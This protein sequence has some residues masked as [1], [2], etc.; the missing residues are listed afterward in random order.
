MRFNTLFG[1]GMVLQRG[2]PIPICGVATAGESIRV[3]LGS[4][5]LQA[6]ANEA[7]DWKVIFPAR[8]SGASLKLSATGS[9]GQFQQF[10]DIVMGD[11]WLASGQSNMGWTIEDGVYE[12]QE[13]IAAANY[14]EIRFFNVPTQVASFPKNELETPGKWRVCSPKSVNQMSA[15]AYFFARKIN[16]E[17]GV[18]IGI[19]LS[20]WGGSSIEAWMP[21]DLVKELPHASG[22]E[23]DFDR[24]GVENYEALFEI[25]ERRIETIQSLIESPA[26]DFLSELASPDIDD[27]DW[28]IRSIPDWDEL[29]AEIH[30]FRKSFDWSGS[31]NEPV[32]ASLGF[33][34]SDIRVFLNGKE[35]FCGYVKKAAFE[36]PRRLLREGRNVMVMRLANPWFA[37][38][39]TGEEAD[40][41]LYGWETETRVPLYEEWRVNGC[42]EPSLPRFYAMQTIPSLLYNG[43][44]EPLAQLRYCGVLWYQGENNGE[45]GYE[46]RALFSA[47]IKCWRTL[48]GQDELPFLFVQLA[49]HGSPNDLPE[50]EGWPCLR[51][52]QSIALDLPMT[53][54][55][56][57]IDVGDEHDIHPQNKKPVGERL[58]LLA[59]QIVYG[60][61]V[62]ANGPVFRSANF[63][64]G[65][66]CIRFTNSNGMQGRGGD[67]ILGFSI[68]GS[69][70]VFHRAEVVVDGGQLW[71][72][73][74]K[75]LEPCSVRYAWAKNPIANLVNEF[76]LPASPFRTDRW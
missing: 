62:V 74:S 37:P 29:P 9:N 60:K 59:Q 64:D 71:V 57:S 23:I 24:E 65:R 8:S 58:A 43:M 68:A 55:A 20:A 56:V 35:L 16:S 47:L 6:V 21:I 69:D 19:I 32:I 67:S 14:P 26:T 61:E 12:K 66:A 31:T 27:S 25:N 40:F 34:P 13:E 49:N 15:V 54:M 70:R 51:E 7:G 41:F 72:S 5:C 36:V 46:Y 4:D 33:S 38:Y 30:W 44:L 28:S 48:L 18:P 39:M 3:Q 17:E 11:V 50:N 63:E 1:S 45:N 52:A 22:P 2:E 53:G 42:L 10:E 75:V 76:G 73:S